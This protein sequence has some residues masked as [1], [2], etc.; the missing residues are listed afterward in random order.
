M[1][2]K[3]IDKQKQKSIDSLASFAEEVIY[4]L[5]TRCEYEGQTGGEFEYALEEFYKNGWK[6]TDKHCYCPNCAEKFNI[7]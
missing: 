7:K 5:C 2:K 6:A 4:I 3:K 1:V